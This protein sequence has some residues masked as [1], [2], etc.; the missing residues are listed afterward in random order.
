MLKKMAKKI[1][2][3]HHLVNMHYSDRKKVIVV[4]SK[5]TKEY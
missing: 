2:L 5:N 3:Q 1:K 4:F